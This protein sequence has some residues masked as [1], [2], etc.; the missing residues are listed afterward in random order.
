MAAHRLQQIGERERAIELF[1]AVLKIRPEEPQSHRD[2]A[3]ALADRADASTDA[4]H[5]Q[6]GQIASD[7]G[8]SLDLLN[9]VIVGHWDRFQEIELPC[10]MEANR[11][12]ATVER[13]KQAGQ[14]AEVPIAL[15]AR[16]R[17][18][19]DCDLRVVMTWDADNTDIDLWVTEPSGEKCFY[20][21]PHD[22]R[23]TSIRATLR[24]AMVLKSIACEKICPANI[25]S[26]P[27]SSAPISRN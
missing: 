17:K 8:R 3:L 6:S 14:I 12:I 22:D 13:L 24:M 20:G 16:L 25:R 5:Q 4:H 10:L 21:Q 7:Y 18:N 1:E 19:L 2:L 27:T 26:R 23:R 9:Q 15:D 11:I